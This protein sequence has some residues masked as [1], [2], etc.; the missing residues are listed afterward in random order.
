MLKIHKPKCENNDITT[1]RTSPE[2]HLHWKKHFHKNV[3]YFRIYADFEADN[4][5]YHSNVG[6]K[7]TNIYNQNPIL[8]GYEIV[9][10]LEDALKSGYYKSPLAYDN[11]DWFVDE[12]I[13]IENKTAFC[14]KNTTKDIIM[15]EKDE[16]DYRKNNICRF[17]EKNIE[18]DE[19]RDHCHLTGK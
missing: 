1:I 15:T 14:L 3:L 12:V 13:E 5:T 7:T 18:S 9:S 19:V 2:P 16:E 10:E 8:N 17:C 11:V 4:E 6:N